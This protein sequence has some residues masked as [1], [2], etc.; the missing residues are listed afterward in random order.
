MLLPIQKL[1]YRYPITTVFPETI[2]SVPG[3]ETIIPTNGDFNV[4]DGFL[5]NLLVLDYRYNRFAVDPRTGLFAMVRFVI[6]I[7]NYPLWLH[8]MI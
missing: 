5:H 2:P 7:P 8:F 6:Q 4:K 3:T 1:N